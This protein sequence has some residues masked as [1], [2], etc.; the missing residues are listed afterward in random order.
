MTAGTCFIMAFMEYF[1]KYV[2]W[3]TPNAN[4]ILTGYIIPSY[5]AA[6]VFSPAV[7]FLVRFMSVK[8]RGKESSE[9]ADIVEIEN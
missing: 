4:I 2:V 3:D 9:M 1:F 6:V 7:Y 5:L 8:L